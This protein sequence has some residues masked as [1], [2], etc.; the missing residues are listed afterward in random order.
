M[1]DTQAKLDELKKA[2]EELTDYVG[3]LLNEKAELKQKLDKAREDLEYICNKEVRQ[4]CS[5][6]AIAQQV[7]KDIE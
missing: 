3:T 7:L 4:L 5:A 1:T 6:E 2:R